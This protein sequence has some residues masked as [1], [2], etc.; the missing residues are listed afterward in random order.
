[1]KGK[2]G[3]MKGKGEGKGKRK[4]R[5]GEGARGGRTPLSQIS[6]SAPDN[7]TNKPY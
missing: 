5:G 3:G 4:G 6:G 2:G 7:V 1:M